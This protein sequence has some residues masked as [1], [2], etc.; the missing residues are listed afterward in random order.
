MNS[1]HTNWNIRLTN[2]DRRTLNDDADTKGYTIV[3]SGEPTFY[4]SN[5]LHRPDVIDVILNNIGVTEEELSVLKELDSDHNPILCEIK[6]NT[7][8]EIKGL[9]KQK[10]TSVREGFIN[11]LNETLPY[12]IN[13]MTTE[14]AYTTLQLFTTTVQE[15]YRNN[16]IIEQDKHNLLCQNLDLDF[17][18]THKREAKRD[19]QMYRTSHQRV[20]YNRLTAQV[21]DTAGQERFRSMA[22]MYYRNANAALLVFDITQYDSLTSV[23]SWVKELKRNVQEP[24]VLCLVGNKCDLEVERKVSKDEALQYACSI[25]ATY[26]ESSA[27]HDQGIEEVFLNVALGLIRLSHETLCSSLRVYDSSSSLSPSNLSS[28]ISRSRFNL[29]SDENNVCE[30]KADA[31]HAETEKPSLCC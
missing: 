9:K 25:G 8:I 7:T 21:W 29:T 10:I 24:M 18:F 27:L 5:P 13:I 3:G 15:A 17:L 16:S 22:P 30:E 28:E 20:A 12:I 31:I 26:F 14:E 23:K 2:R 6:T 1:K 11:T 4:P 19:W